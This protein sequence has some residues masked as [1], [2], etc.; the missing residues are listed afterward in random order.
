MKKAK[1]FTGSLIF[2]SNSTLFAEKSATQ[3]EER[4][5]SLALT[6]MGLSKLP[7][8]VFRLDKIER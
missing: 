7:D 4:H 5:R 3:E 8:D 1:L 6:N 2:E